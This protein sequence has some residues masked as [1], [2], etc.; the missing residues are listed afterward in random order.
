MEWPAHLPIVGG[1]GVSTAI[2]VQ[3]NDPNTLQHS[4][5]EKILASLVG[6]VCGNDSS[7]INKD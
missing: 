6:A 4:L 1:G 5:V 7:L 3:P 2:Q